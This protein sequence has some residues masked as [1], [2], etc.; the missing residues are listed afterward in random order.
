MSS[1]TRRRSKC[2]PV[3]SCLS[4]FSSSLTIARRYI[5]LAYTTRLLSADDTVRQNNQLNLF[6]SCDRPTAILTVFNTITRSA[7]APIGLLLF[8]SVYVL[9]VYQLREDCKCLTYYQACCYC[10]C[11]QI[12]FYVLIMKWQR[13]YVVF[14]MIRLHGPLQKESSCSLLCLACL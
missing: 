2:M 5:L 1:S 4:R 7:T 10:Y 11:F 3:K 13:I 9:L 6:H 12:T 8:I 14:N